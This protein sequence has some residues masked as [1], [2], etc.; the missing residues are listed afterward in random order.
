MTDGV[1]GFTFSSNASAGTPQQQLAAYFAQSIQNGPYI[2]DTNG[3]LIY[4]GFGNSGGLNTD[5]L[6]I[7]QY[8]G[9]PHLTYFNGDDQLPLQGSRGHGVIMNNKYQ[10]IATVTAGLGRT[11]N[12]EHEFTV[13]EDGTAIVTIYQ[14]TQYD[15]SSYGI[16][17]PIGWVVEA[18]FQRIDIQTGSVLFEWRSL[19]HTTP[20]DSYL[21][22]SSNL[23]VGASAGN[24]YDYL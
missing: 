4:S 20:A 17:E 11:G 8:Q 22:F 14:P 1:G 19:D 2:Y 12:D 23:G 13:L 21:P 24:P 9:A 15:L 7:A 6:K 16:D 10:T 5:N 18:V 3:E